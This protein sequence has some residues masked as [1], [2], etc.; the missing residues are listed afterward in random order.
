M[1]GFQGGDPLVLNDAGFRLSEGDSGEAFRR[2]HVLSSSHSEVVTITI[3]SCDLHENNFSIRWVKKIS[4]DNKIEPTFL[5]IILK[6]LSRLSWL[7]VL[8]VWADGRGTVS[9]TH[10]TLPTIYSV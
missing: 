3:R 9:Y 10:L 4:S 8:P 1:T 6:I 7:L 5:K 2:F